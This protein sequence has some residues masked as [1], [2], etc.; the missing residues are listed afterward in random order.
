MPDRYEASAVDRSKLPPALQALCGRLDPLG[1]SPD[2]PA[3][4]CRKALTPPGRVTRHRGF[5]RVGL[6]WRYA[7]LKVYFNIN[8][9]NVKNLTPGEED[10]AGQV[11]YMH[12]CCWLGSSYKIHASEKTDH[13][14]V[15]NQL[16]QWEGERCRP[17]M[18]S[19]MAVWRDAERITE[20]P[21]H[22]PGATAL[23][24][25]ISSG[26]VP[27]DAR[28][29]AR[30]EGSRLYRAMKERPV[31]QLLTLAEAAGVL[32]I[33][34]RKAAEMKASGQLPYIQVGRSVRFDTRDLQ[35][36][37]DE[38]RYLGRQRTERKS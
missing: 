5:D 33:S 35:A 18:K 29:R 24:L 34:R 15:Y 19:A 4:E 37:I 6:V 32:G 12:L 27:I 26:V 7:R 21:E 36:W 25:D 1:W 16:W 11:A 22:E 8:E 20:L 14:D 38:H 3:E 13:A 10:L 17:S 31:S 28:L 9:G 23:L 30:V 2:N